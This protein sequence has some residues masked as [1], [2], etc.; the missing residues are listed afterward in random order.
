MT[1]IYHIAMKSE[2]EQAEKKGEYTADTLASEGFIHCSFKNQV[3]R[4]ADF[5]FRGKND[6]LILCIERKKVEAV[7]KEENVEGGGEELFPHIY[8]PIN[9]ASA[10]KVLPFPPNFDGTFQLPEKFPC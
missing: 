10:V 6:L 5:L 2:W 1:F 9:L 4:V 7:I 3:I 8:G